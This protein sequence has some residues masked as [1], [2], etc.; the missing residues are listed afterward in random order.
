MK[1]RQS[2]YI[3]LYKMVICSILG[4]YKMPNGLLQNDS[5]R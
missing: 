1:E 3:F 2:K 5:E 4:L